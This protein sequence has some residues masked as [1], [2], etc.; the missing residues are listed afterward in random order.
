M[1]RLSRLFLFLG[2]AAISGCGDSVP[3]N[4][5]PPVGVSSAS[6]GPYAASSCRVGDPGAVNAVNCTLSAAGNDT[7]IAPVTE[8]LNGLTQPQTGAL[9]TLTSPINSL[10]QLQSGSLGAITRILQMLVAKDDAALAP[11]IV[12]LSSLL[13]GLQLG[14]EPSQIAAQLAALAAGASPTTTPNGSGGIVVSTQAILDA[15]SQDTLLESLLMPVDN[16][17]DPLNGVLSPVTQ[18][19]DAATDSN[20]GALAGL[21][22]VVNTLTLQQDAALA[23][24]IAGLNAVLGGLAS[25]QDLSTGALAPIAAALGF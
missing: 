2:V 4:S 11:V 12:T 14:Q 25:G 8:L 6:S 19:L 22:D 3:D 15:L 24:V 9:S 13:G 18:P 21:T 17:L 23:P 10:T 7:A 1:N 5:Q 16:L 20:A